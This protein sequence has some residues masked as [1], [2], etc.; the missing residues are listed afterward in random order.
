MSL[1]VVNLRKGGKESLDIGEKICLVGSSG[2]LLG[3]GKGKEIDEITGKV[4]RMNSAC[5]K[6]FEKDVGS[7]CDIRFVAYNAL[8]EVIKLK[9]RLG[10]DKEGA[11]IVLWGAPQHRV[12]GMKNVKGLSG[13]YPKLGIYDIGDGNLMECDKAFH[14]FMGVPRLACGA[15]LSTG[16]VTLCCLLNGGC[17]VSVYGMFGAGQ[18]YHYWDT[19]RGVADSHYKEQQ[20]GAKGHRFLS[21]HK[22]FVDVWAKIFALKFLL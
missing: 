16:W 13:L 8:W 11:C 5:V 19:G 2:V 10:L 15:W 12:S 4:V 20:L 22:V 9:D 18:L 7:R 6:G 14:K 3:R 1:T 17:D 21:E